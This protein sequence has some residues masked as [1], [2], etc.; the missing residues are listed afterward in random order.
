MDGA[1]KN[2]EFLKILSIPYIGG[3]EYRPPKCDNPYYQAKI[4]LNPNPYILTGAE[5]ASAVGLWHA[6]TRAVHAK[7]PSTF[8]SYAQGSRVF[9]P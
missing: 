6:L 1:A 8:M 9:P 7:C 3:L 4:T 5:V 2:T